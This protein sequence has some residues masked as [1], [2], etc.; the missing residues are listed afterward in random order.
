MAKAKLPD[1]VQLVKAL[2]NEPPP[3]GAE[4]FERVQ[5]NSVAEYTPPPQPEA[6]LLASTQLSNVLE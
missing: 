2:E 1:N 6:E 3:N 4:L 5:P